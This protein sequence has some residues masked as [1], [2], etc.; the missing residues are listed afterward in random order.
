MLDRW[1]RDVR[2]ESR[3]IFGGATQPEISRQLW[4]LYKTIHVSG[5]ILFGKNI[6]NKKTKELYKKNGQKR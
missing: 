5:E 4:S 6:W 3:A 1:D 2:D